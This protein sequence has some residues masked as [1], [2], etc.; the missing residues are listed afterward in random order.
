MLSG[1]AVELG[2][3]HGVLQAD[4]G[5]ISMTPSLVGYSIARTLTA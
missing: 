3:Q 5:T 2:F 4:E 1:L